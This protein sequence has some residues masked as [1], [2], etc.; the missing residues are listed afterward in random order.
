M[1][2][3]SVRKEQSGAG[4]SEGG[5]EW[6]RN[7]GRNNE[8]GKDKSK[9]LKTGREKNKLKSLV[10]EGQGEG[11]IGEMEE[12]QR[13]G[14]GKRRQMEGKGEGRIRDW[15]GYGGKMVK[16]QREGRNKG[17]EGGEERGKREAY[18]KRR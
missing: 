17:R 1:G 14:M 8:G 7:R 6:I 5:T 9:L 2:K 10:R 13:K 16:A 12:A 11:G 4:F 18:G 15:N 3:D